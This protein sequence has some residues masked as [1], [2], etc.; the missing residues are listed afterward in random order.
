MTA[1]RA[2]AIGVGRH[3]ADAMG[4]LEAAL[5]GGGPVAPYAADSP[6][7]HL[8]PGGGLPD[9]LALVVGTSG[10]TG[11]AKQAL[12]T[13]DNLVASATATHEVLGGVGSWLLAMPATHI[14]GIQVLVRSLVA[15]TT[16]GFLDLEHG[17]TTAAFVE[18]STAL[19]SQAPDRCY[20]ALVPTQLTRLLDD[21]AGVAALAAYDGVLVGGAATTATVLVA[22][23]QAG[24][25]LVRTYGMSE[26]A[27]GCVYDGAPLPVS[28][29]HID[30]DHHVVLGGATVAHGY[31]GRPEL[32]EDVFSLDADGTRWFRTDDLGQLDED[33]LLEITGRADDLINTGGL[34][35]APGA[36]EDAIVRYVPGVRD[37]VVVGSSD[38]VWGE[39]VCAAL[40]L[41]R[42]APMLALPDVRASLRGLLPDHALP[43]RVLVVDT[44]P[45]RGPGKPDRRALVAAFSAQAGDETMGPTPGRRA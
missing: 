34:K 42:G 15:G 11:L 16:P 25:R 39:A 44:I 38:P 12:L 45:L 18:A 14:A 37:A 26:T 9:R 1:P 13:V 6:T 17:F 8:D 32:T 7:P 24:V 43:H 19:R 31:L 2:L 27:G 28:Q 36:V 22:A 10:S 30:N 20:T 21:P 41:Q 3:A 4:P 35:V 33:G 40:T 23:Q 29:V 5:G